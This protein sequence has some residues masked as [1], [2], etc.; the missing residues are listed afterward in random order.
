MILEK[1]KIHGLTKAQ[2]EAIFACILSGEPGLF[3]GPPGTAKTEIINAIGAALREDSKRQNPTD[4][5]RWFQYQ[6]YDASKLNF[7][8]LTGFPSVKDLAEGRVAFIPTPSSI[9]N[10]HMVAFDE[11]N[12]C[13]EDR[14][15]NL[16]EVIRS[17]KLNGVPTGNRFIF[18][19][20]NPFGDAGTV[21]MSDALVDRHMFYIRFGSFSDMKAEDRVSV[22]LRAGAVDGVGLKYWGEFNSILDTNDN[23]DADGKAHINHALA[24]IGEEIRNLMT[25]SHQVYQQLQEVSSSSVARLIDSVVAVM[26]STF[27]KESEAAKR[28]LLISG[29]R[30]SYVL[31]G[32]LAVR[33]VQLASRKEDEELKDFAGVISDCIKLSLPIGIGGKLNKDLVD[34]AN[35]CVE[36]TVL[37]QWPIVNKMENTKDINLYTEALNSNDP[38]II[39]NILLSLNINNQT[40]DAI[41]GG[42]MDKKKYTRNNNFDDMAYKRVQLVLYCLNNTIP[43]YIPEHIKLDMTASATEELQKITNFGLCEHLVPYATFID[44]LNTE[45]KNDPLPLA[46]LRASL[47]YHAENITSKAHALQVMINTQELLEQLKLKIE[48]HKNVTQ[49]INKTTTGKKDKKTAN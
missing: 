8:D 46:A 10:K 24:D 14:Q 36:D 28:E 2:E 42:L 35:T 13:A 37:K 41:L 30:A 1:L 9:W 31:R 33:A 45:Y 21:Q 44:S 18:S 39:L 29:R 12:R 27:S 5:S 23:L 48:H 38:I 47:G 3:I 43:G 26:S 19:T 32:I 22:V 4:P 7:E 20:I 25:K 16:L 6:V 17:R 11:L 40:R 34:K 49:P 15:G